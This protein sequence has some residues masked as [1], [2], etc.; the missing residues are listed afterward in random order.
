MES[1]TT[2][3]LQ[4]PAATSA[5]VE[6]VKTSMSAD[7][8]FERKADGEVQHFSPVLDAE[9]RAS[10]EKSC[11]ELFSLD[12]NKEADCEAAAKEIGNYGKVAHIQS[13]AANRMLKQPLAKLAGASEEGNELVKNIIAVKMKME[14]MHPNKYNLTP[15]FWSKYLGFLPFIGTPARRYFSK[16]QEGDAALDTMFKTLQALGEERKRDNI[17]LTAK[18]KEMRVLTKYLAKV[19]AKGQH[20]KKRIEEYCAT[21]EP[22]DQKLQFFQEEILYT[23]NQRIMDIGVQLLASLQ[24]IM[25]MGL[26][27]NMNIEAIRL[28]E[29]TSTTTRDVLETAM[30][31]AYGQVGLRM[32]LKAA[33]VLKSF[34]EDLIMDNA[35]QMGVAQA[36][37]QKLS[38]EGILDI[39][40]LV[41]GMDM[42]IS[43]IDAGEKYRR[44]ALP[45]MTEMINKLNDANGRAE[46]KVSKMERGMDVRSKFEA[47]LAA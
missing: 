10:A 21:L 4:P 16:F 5:M 23:L 28:V 35:K 19:V 11:E 46:E 44:E 24:A 8:G 12:L 36:D 20:M 14:D 18:R 32:T 3:V 9:L 15:G 6:S 30:I 45:R 22:G 43:T 2:T 41:Q 31:I 40:K 17:Q 13:S 38:S 37:V 47:D 34:T 39:D 33:Q 26:L 42:V 25:S 27:V 1:G 29:R 7:L